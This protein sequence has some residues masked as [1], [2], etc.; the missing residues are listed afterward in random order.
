MTSRF[1]VIIRLD[2]FLQRLMYQYELTSRFTR[3][4]GGVSC[5][6]ST[7]T[8]LWNWVYGEERTS[9]DPKSCLR[10]LICCLHLHHGELFV[11]RRKPSLGVGYHF[12]CASI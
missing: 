12:C 7:W 4:L 8:Y 1:P 5:L 2:H 9:Y 3:E 6:L 10:I 11:D